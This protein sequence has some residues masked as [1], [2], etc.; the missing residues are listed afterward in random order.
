MVLCGWYYQLNIRMKLFFGFGMVVM[1]LLVLAAVS[2]Y[3]IERTRSANEYINWALGERHGRVVNVFTTTN[4]LQERLADLVNKRGDASGVDPLVDTFWAHVDKIQRVRFPVQADAMKLAG[5]EVKE[6]YLSKFKPAIQAGKLDVARDVLAA[7]ITGRLSIVNQSCQYMIAQQV[8]E[9]LATGQKAADPKPL[10]WVALMTVGALAASIGIT[11]ATSNYCRRC[12]VYLLTRI[13]GLINRD[14]DT[15]IHSPFSD[16]FGKIAVK[17]NDLRKLQ[18]NL[19]ND[20]D[21]TIKEAHV[22]MANVLEHME[23]LA[24]HSGEAESCATTVSAATDRM[25]QSTQDIVRTCN[26]ANDYSTKSREITNSGIAQAK[27]GINGILAQ[28]EQTRED[29]K[30]IEAMV[31]QSR[32]INTIVRT[33][34]EIA[35]QTNLLALNAAIEAARAGEAGRGFAVVADEV[36]ALASRTSTS[37]DEINQIVSLIE[38]D[39]NAASDSMGRSIADMD[40]LAQ[41]STSLEEILSSIL[42]HVNDLDNQIERITAAVEQQSVASEEISSHINTLTDMSQSVAEISSMSVKHLSDTSE[43][44]DAFY[45]RLRGFSRA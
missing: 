11:I 32:N 2:L 35:N 10:L 5:R 6:I 42:S 30:Q 45:E 3:T 15:D 24:E 16:E 7:E 23:K 44:M 1:F 43:K 28:A 38:R 36:R 9:T 41:S 31:N 40:T 29:G 37:I 18:Q 20:F 17:L 8:K 33:I 19:I 22:N 4:T 34:D 12:V 14:F 21:A 27:A 13:D 39:A 26:I 25:V